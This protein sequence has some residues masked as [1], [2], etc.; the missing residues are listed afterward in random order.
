MSR[1]SWRMRWKKSNFIYIHILLL[2]LYLYSF[3]FLFTSC[4]KF[5][6]R[7]GQ[8]QLYALTTFNPSGGAH[9]ILCMSGNIFFVNFLSIYFRPRNVFHICKYLDKFH[10][11]HSI[12]KWGYFIFFLPK[13]SKPI[14]G[15]F[16][17]YQ[18][19]LS[20]TSNSFELDAAI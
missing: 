18:L 11:H 1:E 2:L 14:K 5:F 17:I 8:A 10:Y 6:Q 20:N 13:Y 3:Y 9:L 7:K 16:V 15:Q 19:F 4:N 12:S